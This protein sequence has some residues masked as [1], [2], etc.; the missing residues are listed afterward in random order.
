MAELKAASRLL[1]TQQQ[2]E[3]HGHEALLDKTSYWSFMAAGCLLMARSSRRFLL[4]LRSAEVSDPHVWGVWSGAIDKGEST[5]NTVRRELREE[6]ALFEP[7][8]L[9]PMLVYRDPER[10][11]KF[12]NFLGI[13]DHEFEPELNWET[14]L[15]KWFELD[16]FPTPLHPGLQALLN[17]DPSR[18]V[19]EYYMQTEPWP[20]RDS[21][22]EDPLGLGFENDPRQ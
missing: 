5:E 11:F 13:V 1:T 8:T 6:A 21:D 2:F 19:I 3:D 12:F 22:L 16:G 9:V 18:A 17:D 15:A 14:E 10:C 20:D 4:P 7:V